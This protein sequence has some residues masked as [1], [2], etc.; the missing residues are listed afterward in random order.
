M[1][2]W[3]GTDF[4]LARWGFPH[5]P[6]FWF[7]EPFPGLALAMCLQYIITSS[8]PPDSVSCGHLGISCRNGGETDSRRPG[9]GASGRGS[10]RRVMEGPASWPC[11]GVFGK[12]PGLG[13]NQTWGRPE[14]HSGQPRGPWGS[15]LAFLAAGLRGGRMWPSRP[16]GFLFHSAASPALPACWNVS[17]LGIF[18]A[19]TFPSQ[20]NRFQLEP[21]DSSAWPGAAREGQGAR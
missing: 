11:T 1:V 16:Q 2:V 18:T 10:G 5:S 19:R 9:A 7:L 6:Q 14:S 15:V 8:F 13:E 21:G 17:R 4:P 20:S 12:A 3:P